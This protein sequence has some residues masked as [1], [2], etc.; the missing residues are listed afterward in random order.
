MANK[1]NWKHYRLNVKER[2]QTIFNSYWNGIF[3]FIFNLVVNKIKDK[4]KIKTKSLVKRRIVLG[5]SD[6]EADLDSWS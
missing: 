6:N 4:D 1:K 2:F 5:L 3:P